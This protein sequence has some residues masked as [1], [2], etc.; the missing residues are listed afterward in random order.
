M[1]WYLALKQ[2]YEALADK[3][4]QIKKK[5]MTKV[6]GF[7]EFELCGMENQAREH[8]VH[9]IIILITKKYAN[10]LKYSENKLI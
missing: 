8:C 4:G 7:Q 1:P 9:L 3:A 5:A 6:T 2:K 10:R